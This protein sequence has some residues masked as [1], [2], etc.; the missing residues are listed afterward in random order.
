MAK[1][2][3][4][5]LLTTFILAA[6]IFG[7]EAGKIVGRVLPLAETLSIP[8]Q[9]SEVISATAM[10]LGISELTLGIIAALILG[11]IIFIVKYGK[12]CCE[13]IIWIRDI[14]K[15]NLGNGAGEKVE[16]SN[17]EFSVEELSR[18]EIVKIKKQISKLSQQ[19][20]AILA[21][22][23]QIR[24]KACKEALEDNIKT[25]STEYAMKFELKR[26]DFEKAMKVLIF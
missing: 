13:S 19:V 21:E 23:K 24:E 7:V 15:M 14:L 5:I 3:T 16:K 12:Q 18:E 2:L 10:P 26:P 1:I 20:R 4:I 25:A 6:K 9:K 11:C 8:V 17:T 22:L